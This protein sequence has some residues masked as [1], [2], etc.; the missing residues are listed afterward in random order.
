MRCVVSEALY[1]HTKYVNIGLHFGET[2]PLRFESQRSV[3]CM[4]SPRAQLSLLV[5]AT[6]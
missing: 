5:G 1:S 6:T 4:S 3:G 2:N